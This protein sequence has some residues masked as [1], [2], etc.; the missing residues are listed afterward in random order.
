MTEAKTL[1]PHL[2][3]RQGAGRAS[4]EVTYVCEMASTSHTGEPSLIFTHPIDSLRPDAIRPKDHHSRPYLMAATM[5]VKESSISRMSAASLAT[6]V[7]LFIAKPTSA[8]LRAGA[9]LV[10]SP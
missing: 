9:S 2:D 1:R 4:K 8:A 5:E 10:P 7:P 3:I 6:E